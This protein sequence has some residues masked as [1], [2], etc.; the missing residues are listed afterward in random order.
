MC[1]EICLGNNM[2]SKG[3][4]DN[5]THKNF[6]KANQIEQASTRR[7]QFVVFLKKNILSFLILLFTF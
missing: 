3:I 6:K 1:G 7:V 4:L 2:I 5:F